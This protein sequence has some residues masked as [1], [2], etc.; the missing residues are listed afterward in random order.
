MAMD[1]P[2]RHT[3]PSRR[4]SIS[5]R[6]ALAC[7]ALALPIAVLSWFMD[8][9]FRHDISIGHTGLAGTALMRRTVDVMRLVTEHRVLRL[10]AAAGDAES[11]ARLVQT[12]ERT[13]EAFKAFRA[14]HDTFLEALR[15]APGNVAPDTEPADEPHGLLST[16]RD[17]RDGDDGYATLLR[18]LATLMDM[19]GERT[20]AAQ[21][22][23]P[24]NRDLIE[25]TV[26]ALAPLLMRVSK[27]EAMAAA[28]MESPRT[29][30]SLADDL[31]LLRDKELAD[32][33]RNSRT[34][35]R[36]APSSRTRIPAMEEQFRTAL[37]PL[38]QASNDLIALL[39]RSPEKDVPATDLM[40]AT[41]AVRTAGHHLLDVG[42]DALD[43]MILARI[44]SYQR[45]RLMGASFS[46][47]AVLALLFLAATVRRVARSVRNVAAY[48][49]RVSDGDYDTPVQCEGDVAEMEDMALA[50]K[51]MVA[52]LK[53]KIG[54]LGGVLQGMTVPCLAVDARERLTFINQ[55]YLDL[56]ERDGKPDDYL[57]MTV[58]ELFYGNPDSP[59][60]TG[61]CLRENRPYTNMTVEAKSARGNMVSVRYNVW[62]I[63]DLDG[64]I[65]GA[66]AVLV[67]LTEI[68]AQQMEIQR[69]AAF[70]EVSP[71]PTLS[72]AQDGSIIYH[73]EAAEQAMRNL[74]LLDRRDFLPDNHEEIT[75]ACLASGQN[76]E[77]EYGPA[78]S[79]FLWNYHPLPEQG[80]VH[81]YASDI[82]ARKRA[83][84]QLL[85][86]AF[87]DGLTGLPNKA[88]FLDRLGQATRRAQRS[89]EHDFAV[90]ML[91]MDGF[92][93][94]NDSLGHHMGDKL[95][96]DVAA[97]L[98]RNLRDSDT[99]ARLGG[100][101]FG[102]IM[103]PLGGA[104][105]ALAM[106]ERIAETLADPFDIEHN[107]L[108]VSAAVGIVLGKSGRRTADELLRD[109][110]TAMF[111]AK[112]KGK[113][114]H[115]VF[116]EAMHQAAL[117]RLTLDS[118]MKRAMEANEFEPFYQ[119]LVDLDTGH[120]MGFEALVRWRSPDKGLIPP[121]LFIPLAEETG[122][123]TAIGAFMLD[124][125]CRQAVVWQRLTG[126]KDLTMSVNL[127][128]R[129]MI[130]PGIVDEIAAVLRATGIEA[131]RV[132][133]E[134][135]ESGIMEN[136]DAARQVLQGLK[137]LGVRLAIDDFGTGYSSLAHLH[138]FPFDYLKVDQS[139]VSAMEETRENR[140]IIETIV[141][142]G[143]SLGKTIIAEGV[144]TAEELAVLRA[145]GC[146]IGQGYLFARPLPAPEAEVLLKD[147][148]TW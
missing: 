6:L 95:L 119:P 84:R 50:I 39:E 96:V 106:A 136:M 64:D 125:A 87:H 93:H 138:R 41:R 83:E 98:G 120:I 70:P 59:T 20:L 114:E 111:R 9:S 69:L 65:I 17:I 129:Q 148:P 71:I 27:I 42:L 60:I 108:W 105:L 62:P 57:G 109:A 134:I 124:A 88:L 73:N 137:D 85:H 107:E 3:R 56:Y 142:L 25:A 128:V 34:A 100:D 135:T 147:N 44:A 130:R 53:E 28:Y 37:E 40:A 52:T 115:C 99:L 117:E 116:D 22:A 126:F 38:V 16:W 43:S 97:R 82:T 72:V 46:G 92:K 121:G 5:R 132:K 31:A 139:F 90:L 35:L 63:H 19:V 7:L 23:I 4:M 54:Y 33:E 131:S 79:T 15:L 2:S 110:D 141:G 58:G 122:L 146:E 74:G 75:A 104:E 24:Y 12:S 30:R 89:E 45:W 21:D 118:A 68:K 48:A 77:I 140:E 61:R 127:A 80:R 47:A 51:R 144:E 14:A 143:H 86:D 10:R 76:S 67:D 36:E 113:G 11:A 66:F 102:I 101:E 8:S 123:V 91:D 32:V 29:M 78:D 55:P 49:G 26:D 94:V 103:E 13:Y 133:I 112:A 145:M 1:S 81:V 18:E